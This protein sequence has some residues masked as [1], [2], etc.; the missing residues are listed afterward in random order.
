MKPNLTIL[1]SFSALKFTGA[2]TQEFLQG[3]LTCDMRELSAH[4]SHSLAAVCDH[5]G[6]MLANFWVI[7]W[8]NDFLL[9]L[10]RSL[11]DTVKNHLQ[12][13]AQFSKVIISNADHFF[14]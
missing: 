5:R 8:H 12:K 11:S 9:I 3:Q 14:I 4:G 6:R 2:K 7:N 13:Y 10:P 1:N